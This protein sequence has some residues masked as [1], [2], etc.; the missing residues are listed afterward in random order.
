[1]SYVDEV[2]SKTVE[3]NPGEYE[4]HQAVKEILDSLKLVIDSDEKKYRD[5]SLLE[6]LIEPE[7]IISFR[8]PWVDD[9]G[10]L[11]INKGYRIQYNSAIGP[12]KGG[13]RFHSSVNLNLLKFLGFEQTF[14]NALT[15]L[16]IGGA[17]GGSNFD[18]KGK[19]EREIMAFCQSFMSE[20]FKYIGDDLDIPAGDIGAGS[21]E[22][23]FLFGQYKRLAGLHCGAL[24]GKGPSFGGSPIRT[25][26]TGYGLVYMLENMLRRHGKGLDGK[27]VVISGAG[28]VAVHT[29]E[30]IQQFGAKVVTLS[31][32]NGYIYDKDGI[33]LDVVKQIKEVRRGRIK[34][35]LDEVPTAV[36]EE[37]K[38]IWNIPC[39]I[40]LPCATQNELN[41]Q[42][43][44]TLA[45]NGCI[46]VVEGANMPCNREATDFL[47]GSHLL[48]MPGKAANGGGV[49]VSTLEMRQNSMRMSWT[50]DEVDEQLHK[51]MAE[52]YEKTSDAA[53]R[54]GVKGNFVAGANIAAFEKIA[55][56]MM[57]QGFV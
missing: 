53:E 49:A 48:F 37:N 51:I 35:Y 38:R 9:S 12:Y 29:I 45:A 26:A 25:Q 28:S 40:A 54:Y 18:R 19:S 16:P 32:S 13:L 3:D 1:M 4:F 52:I 2:Y 33:R 31:D 14:K 42:D 36:Y 55:D 17:K 46:A 30:K 21:R 7:R 22:I 20:L 24:T 23:G 8:V 6:R 10:H 44:R 34:E 11:Q 41:L 43:A 57:S 47:L 56:A 39:H 15:G 50:F 27:V 5:A